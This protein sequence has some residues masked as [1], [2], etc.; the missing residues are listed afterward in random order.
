MSDRQF[1]VDLARCTG[2]QTCSI[3][4]KDRANLPDG[5]DWLR[6]EANESGKYPAPIL[7]YRVIHCFHCARPPCV[8]VCPTE[9]MV[10]R[11][12][13]WVQVEAEL[14][15]AC[16]ACVEACPFSAI[17]IRP[18]DVASKCDGCA[19]EISR[20]WKPTCVRACP[21]RALDYGPRASPLPDKRV[22]D[23]GFRD[24]GIGPA[25]LYLRRPEDQG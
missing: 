9:A 18:G 6:V 17:I 19:D 4:C 5:L 13:G 11:E 25:V 20:G 14:C 22:E 8:E 12:D 23:R 1:A 3:A 24:H 10:K 7:Y 21:M 15:I 2:C 16:G